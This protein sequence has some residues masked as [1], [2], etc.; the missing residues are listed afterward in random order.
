MAPPHQTRSGHHQEQKG[1]APPRVGEE[2]GGGGGAGGALGAG[3]GGVEEKERKK[4]KNGKRKKHVCEEW[5]GENQIASVA[6][7]DHAKTPHRIML[8]HLIGSC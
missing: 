3:A 1:C 5:T 4:R 7:S 6:S 2:G 8:K